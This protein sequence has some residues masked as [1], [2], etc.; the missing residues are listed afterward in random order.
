[1]NPIDRNII[2][3]EE[4]KTFRLVRGEDIMLFRIG[5]ATFFS[6]RMA[7]EKY[8][9]SYKIRY[10]SLEHA[11]RTWKEFCKNGWVPQR[12]DNPRLTRGV[13]LVK[14]T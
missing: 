3:Q 11:R 5:V 7:H 10:E 9:E 6:V 12:L 4:L 13:V 1:M 2:P 14:T 8:G